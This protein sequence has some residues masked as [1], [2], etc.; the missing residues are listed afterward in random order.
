MRDGTFRATFF[1]F[2]FPTVG[3]KAGVLLHV[4]M[5]TTGGAAICSSIADTNL[6]IEKVNRSAWSVVEGFHSVAF[7]LSFAVSMDLCFEKIM[8]SSQTPPPKK[9]HPKKVQM[10]FL[11]TWQSKCLFFHHLFI[12]TDLGL[13]PSFLVGRVKLQ[14]F[15]W[16]IAIRADWISGVSRGWWYTGFCSSDLYCENLKPLDSHK[17]WCFSRDGRYPHFRSVFSP[18][19]FY[20]WSH[21]SSSSKYFADRFECMGSQQT[22][23]HNKGRHQM[24]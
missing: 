9:K 1:F 10:G 22:L 4:S 21:D 16:W 13:N 5:P 12:P 18:H 7:W 6:R 14:Q 23:F 17:F 19:G 24:C 20:P 3:L 15:N 8:E 11:Q 2:A